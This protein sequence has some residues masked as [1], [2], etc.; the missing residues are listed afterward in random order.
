MLPQVELIDQEAFLIN[1]RRLLIIAEGFEERSISFLSS[2]EKI[3]FDRALV[4]KYFPPKESKYDELMKLV[5][6]KCDIAEI[7]ELSFNRYD[8]FEFEN[9]LQK[10]FER[11]RLFDEV[12]VD[13]SVMSKY[14]I[15]QIICS[16]FDYKGILKLIYTEPL[17][18]APSENELHNE[19]QRAAT[20]LPSSGVHDIVRTPL[21]TSI[22]MQKSPALLVAF[23]SFNEQLI[24][25]LLSEYNPMHLF[26]INGVP[27][28]LHWREK[29]M[30]DIHKNIINEYSKDNLVDEN[31]VLIRKTSTLDYTDTFNLLA[32]IYRKYCVENRIVLA[33][34]GSKMQSVGCALLK[35]CC[36]D[37]HIEYP[38]PESY[39]VAGYSSSEIREIHQVIFENIYSLIKQIS[40]IY[41]LNQ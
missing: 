29:A 41:E 14:M 30:S 22:I 28:H 6:Q 37:V 4:C 23:L 16:M 18:Y 10:E 21:L 5:S 15:M 19:V 25:A 1:K 11:V 17:S 27:P 36:P 9:Q 40:H 12:V 38:T 24:R 33:P 26:L 7:K 31:G 8:P 35:L 3:H 20:I 32:E 13:I 2:S 39:Y 34:T